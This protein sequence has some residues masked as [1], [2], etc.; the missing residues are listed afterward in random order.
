MSLPSGTAEYSTDIFMPV[1]LVNMISHKKKQLL[2]IIDIKSN[3][4]RLSKLMYTTI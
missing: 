2:S 4:K 3:K 1:F